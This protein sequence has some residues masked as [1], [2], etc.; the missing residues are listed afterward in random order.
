MIFRY[1]YPG[2]KKQIIMFPILSLLTGLCLIFAPFDLTS[3]LSL[4]ISAA[5]VLAP[6]GLAHKD[7]QATMGMLPVKASEK[8]AF[9]LIYFWIVVAAL[10][11]LPM[12]AVSGIAYMMDFA[13]VQFLYNIYSVSLSM[14]SPVNV[15]MCQFVAM[16]FQMMVLY[17]V[18]RATVNRTMKGIVTGICIY[19]GFVFVSAFSAGF[20]FAFKMVDYVENNPGVSETIDEQLDAIE[21]N[22]PEEL[23]ENPQALRQIVEILEGDTM[24]REFINGFIMCISMLGLA[25]LIV[26]LVL[27]YKKLQKG[28]F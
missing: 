21:I 28:G 4:V 3:F 15:V 14:I 12:I 8:L 22:N 25:L 9:L 1:V 17:V 23:Y 16:S 2:L 27:I 26:E 7:Y 6:I 11:Y 18:T 5:Y 13:K 19:F 24:I 20:Y 10:L